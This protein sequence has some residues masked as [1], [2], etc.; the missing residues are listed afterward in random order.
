MELKTTLNTFYGR[1]DN[2]LV[3]R[4]GISVSDVSEYVTY[5]VTTIPSSSPEIDLP[6][7]LHFWSTC[8]HPS[9]AG[10]CV[11]LYFMC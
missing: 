3:V 8:D 6:N 1:H 2:E 10:V 11:A 4:Y 5:V 9:F 7:V